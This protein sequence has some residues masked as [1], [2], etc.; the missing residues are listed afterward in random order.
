MFYFI[1]NIIVNNKKKLL[2]NNKN[3]N[4]K[5]NNKKGFEAK[6]GVECLNKI[7]TDFPDDKELMTK[8]QYFATCAQ[9]AGEY[10]KK[11]F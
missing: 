5:N 2:K 3:N 6:F 8:F 4:N 9:L 7:Q 1:L 11:F 10:K